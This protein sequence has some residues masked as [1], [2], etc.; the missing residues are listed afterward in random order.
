LVEAVWKRAPTEREVL[1]EVMAARDEVIAILS[2]DG[3]ITE[4]DR[5]RHYEQAQ[6]RLTAAL[7]ALYNAIERYPELTGV[8]PL[9]DSLRISKHV[10]TGWSSPAAT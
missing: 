10:R 4:P 6:Q 7:D 2:A 3:F 8:R 5:F 1:T 9:L